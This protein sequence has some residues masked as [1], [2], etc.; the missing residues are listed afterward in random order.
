IANR[1]M[2]VGSGAIVDDIVSAEGAK[3]SRLCVA[4]SCGDDT[5]AKQLGELQREQRYAAGA[6]RQHGLSG[7]KTP[8]AR[9]RVPR[10]NTRARESRSFFE[11]EMVRDTYDRVF[12]KDDVF[13]QHAI[14]RAANLRAVLELDRTVTPIGKHGR[15]YSVANR[16]AAHARTDGGD[17]PGAVGTHDHVRFHWQRIRA[18]QHREFS[19]VERVRTHPNEHLAL[20]GVRNRMIFCCEAKKASTGFGV[21]ALHFRTPSDFDGSMTENAMDQLF[22][23]RTSR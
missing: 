22:S 12:V 13:R 7:A 23:S 19:S 2:P 11:G 8:G 10:R 20:P 16:D 14:E 21:V 9:Q 6:K 15:R 3:T 1:R 4:G 18:C 5:R 17:L